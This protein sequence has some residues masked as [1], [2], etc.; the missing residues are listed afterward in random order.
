MENI[1]YL[2]VVL[3]FTIAVYSIIAGIAGRL[4]KNSFL[5]VSAQRGVMTT[6]ALTTVASG[7]LLAAILMDDFRLNYVA[8][9]SSKAQPLIYQFAAWWGGARRFPALLGVD[10]RYLLV[11][12]R[13]HVA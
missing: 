4:T 7:V 11:C 1:G 2:A 3:G 10:R 12:R 5:E 6:W 8:S 13:L 9:Y